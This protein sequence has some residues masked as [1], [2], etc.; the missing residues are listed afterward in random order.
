VNSA[1]KKVAAIQHSTRCPAI[2][3]NRL[4]PF[5]PVRLH[6][7]SPPPSQSIFYLLS[8]PP[9]SPLACA[10]CRRPVDPG[11]RCVSGSTPFP[12]ARARAISPR[13]GTW[14]RLG[15]PLVHPNSVASHGCAAPSAESKPARL[16][17]IA[18]FAHAGLVDAPVAGWIGA[19]SPCGS[20]VSGGADAPTGRYG[21]I[22]NPQS[23]DGEFGAP[24]T[25]SA[26]GDPGAAALQVS[27]VTYGLCAAAGPSAPGA[28]TLAPQLRTRYFCRSP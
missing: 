28:P 14:P 1:S 8:P 6:P 7:S 18:I 24:T 11:F 3:Q 17:P 4:D 2:R 10:R 15:R 13:V 21:S 20:A 19:K 27:C 26:V 9:S 23:K 22:G 12:S 16:G 25:P 5:P